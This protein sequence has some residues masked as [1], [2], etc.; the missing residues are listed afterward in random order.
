M[1]LV[2]YIYIQYIY[3]YMCLFIHIQY[4]YIYIYTYI[5]K[6]IYMYIYIYTHIYK[7]IYIY[8]NLYGLL[9]KCAFTCAFGEWGWTSACGGKV[10]QP[11]PWLTSRLPR[12]KPHT[13]PPLLIPS[14]HLFLC[15]PLQ[16]PTP[17]TTEHPR[18]KH[19][20]PPSSSLRGSQRLCKT[21]WEKLLVYIA[22]I[23][24]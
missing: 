14:P 4:I 9:C 11:P 5:Y 2:I 16:R 18:N 17:D 8:I 22:T 12:Q 3:I 13:P 21:F 23:I 20:L 1:C 10:V 19:K 15:S 6:Y 24:R 7:D